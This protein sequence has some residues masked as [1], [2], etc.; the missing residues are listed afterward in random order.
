MHNAWW[1]PEYFQS[2]VCRTATPPLFRKSPQQHEATVSGAVRFCG[3]SSDDGSTSDLRDICSNMYLSGGDP[4]AHQ[5]GTQSHIRRGSHRAS[6]GDPIAHPSGGYPIVHQAGIPSYIRR[7]SHRS[8]GHPIA[9]QADIVDGRESFLSACMAT[10]T[11][12]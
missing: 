9:H 10:S 7:V 2:L 8:S 6:D 11:A 4:I 3:D 1:C 5:A 12:M